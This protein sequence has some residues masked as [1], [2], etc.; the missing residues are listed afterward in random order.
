[1]ILNVSEINFHYNMKTIGH[2]TCGMKY[3]SPPPML[4]IYDYYLDKDECADKS[5]TCHREHA[6]CTNSEG[7]F[8]CQCHDG[9]EGDGEECE[10][11]VIMVD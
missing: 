1:M 7:S 9:F 5:H 8:T 2:K 6:N 4:H 10:G 11:A 3:M